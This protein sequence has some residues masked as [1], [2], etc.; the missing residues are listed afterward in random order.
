MNLKKCCFC[1]DLKTA[2]LIFGT[3]C[4]FN[5]FICL[6][7][8]K[9]L[10]VLIVTMPVITYIWLQF[11]DTKRVRFAFFVTYTSYQV[12][13]QGVHLYMKNGFEPT[14]DEVEAVRHTCGRIG[15]M[16]GF[17]TSDYEGV[18]DCEARQ[19]A[20][21][22]IFSNIQLGIGVFFALYFPFVVYAYYRRSDLPES[23]GGCP[24]PP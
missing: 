8:A 19:I 16:S 22:R 13:M 14:R 17:A 9:F 11:R 24:K 2:I 10:H 6:Y 4:V 18:D 5:W 7:A 15:Y 21:V 23:L 3:S 12:L 20:L 1:I